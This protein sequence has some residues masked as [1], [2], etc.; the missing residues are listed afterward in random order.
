MFVMTIMHAMH[1]SGLDLNQLPVLD[2]LLEAK[3]VTVAAKQLGL[4]QSATSHAL[5]R[6]RTTFDDPLLVRSPDGMVLTARA[7]SLRAPVREALEAVGKAF[8]GPV[9]FDPATSERSYSIAS[10]DY[11]EVELF[12]QLLAKALPQ[13][14]GIQVWCRLV[15][16]EL[17][18]S[19]IDGSID[20]GMSPPRPE[21]DLPG[22]RT[23]KLFEDHFV[24]LVRK[25]HPS[26]KKRWTAASFAQLS[27]AFIA[28]R[29][30]PGGYVDT[31]LEAIGLSRHIAFA[32]PHFMVAPFVIA[33]TD[34][35]LT[36]PSR[37]A[38]VIVGVLDLE[39]VKPPIELPPLPMSMFW[40]ER[41]DRDPGHVWLREMATRP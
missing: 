8:S 17:A 33:S 5:A 7:E 22:I 18:P 10:A 6:L 30:R 38:K 24:S 25:G 31:A 3:S 19:L 12:P 9:A 41:L 39:L 16:D 27:H 11:L 29:G 1:L 14:P 20:L 34:L 32:T 4:S 26:L 2:A 28:P 35:V 40:H 21:L 36:I 15:G 37:A 13:A 23:K